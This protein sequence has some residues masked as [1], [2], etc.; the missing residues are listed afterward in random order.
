M[1]RLRLA[2]L[3][4][5]VATSL[6]AQSPPPPPGGSAP[7]VAA[8]SPR[9]ASHFDAVARVDGGEP[10]GLDLGIANRVPVV[11]LVVDKLERGEPGGRSPARRA[12]VA[13]LFVDV[14]GWLRVVAVD[15]TTAAIVPGELR[16][17]LV[18]AVGV[19]S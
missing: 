19:G 8:V 9:R 4:L 11:A 10:F 6:A 18:A 2:I 12:A 3:P 13:P 17:S 7:P 15:A 1:H 5:L 16:A 14:S